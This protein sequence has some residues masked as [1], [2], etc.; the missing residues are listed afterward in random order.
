M[1]TETYLAPATGSMFNSML[2]CKATA[3]SAACSGPGRTPCLA[4]GKAVA[5]KWYFA[6]AEALSESNSCSYELFIAAC[7]CLRRWSVCPGPHIVH[8]HQQPLSDFEEALLLQV[9]WK[10][11]Q[12][13]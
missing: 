4:R 10:Q 7:T 12:S 13:L 8:T 11:P 1:Q 9:C 5:K 2:E 6:L 3:C